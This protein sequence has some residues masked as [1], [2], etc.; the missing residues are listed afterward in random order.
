MRRYSWTNPVLGD[1]P[2][3]CIL[4]VGRTFYAYGTNPGLGFRAWSSLDLET[5][6]DRGLVLEAG[7][8]AG[9]VNFWAPHVVAYKAGYLLAYACDAPQ[10]SVRV[11]LA[12]SPLGPFV[13]QSGPLLPVTALDPFVFV[14]APDGVARLFWSS[15]GGGREQGVWCGELREW[16]VERPRFLF[17][18]ARQPERWS[19]P[20]RPTYSPAVFRRGGVYYCVYACNDAGPTAGL[21]YATA[22]DLDGPWTK[23]S[24]D[25][26]L[27]VPGVWGG[28]GRGGS[29]FR[30]ALCAAQDPIRAPSGPA[31]SAP[32]LGAATNAYGFLPRPPPGAPAEDPLGRTAPAPPAAFPPAVGP[33]GPSVFDLGDGWTP[34]LA[35]HVFREGADRALCIDQLQFGS[36]GGGGGAA[37]GGGGAGGGE[38]GGAAARGGGAFPPPFPPPLSVVACPPRR[39]AVVREQRSLVTASSLA[40]LRALPCLPLVDTPVSNGETTL[41]LNARLAGGTWSMTYRGVELVEP[42]PGNGGSMQ[43]ACCFDIGPGE[44]SELYNPTEAGNVCDSGGITSSR[45]LALKARSSGAGRTGPGGLSGSRGSGGGALGRALGGSPAGPPNDEAY[46]E[47]WMAYYYPP[48]RPVLSANG[49]LPR[50]AT[51]LSEVTLRKHVRFGFG[52]LPNAIDYRVAFSPNRPWEHWFA[53]WEAVTGYMA[54]GAFSD[55]MVIDGE[56]L[57]ARAFALRDGHGGDAARP[58]EGL[59]L[60]DASGALAFGAWCYQYPADGHRYRGPDCAPWMG[61][62]KVVGTGSIKFAFVQ[63][64]NAQVTPHDQRIASTDHVF[65]FVF[66]TGTRETVREQLTTIMASGAVKV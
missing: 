36:G 53:Q 57:D 46:T 50:C 43:S 7:G 14:D 35:Y 42:Q 8:L 9:S 11:A 19:G 54:P 37:A 20:E 59:V 38:G 33:G 40:S 64:T 44:S 32:S 58:T 2:D 12:A 55:A 29:P 18:Q 16:R 52:T 30:E 61:V 49:A 3:P 60:S 62:D 23:R 6:T 10:A 15:V 21:A 28:D 48:G 66:L 65:G 63:H 26:P 1:C 5:W 45:W 4:R 56:T 51:V 13:P 22:T 31:G 34:M 24:L 41:Y 47:T 39:V 27:A 17:G 25:A